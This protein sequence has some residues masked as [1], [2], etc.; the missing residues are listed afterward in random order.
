MRFFRDSWSPEPSSGLLELQEISK[1][2]RFWKRNLG[3]FE[4]EECGER[5]EELS[6][7]SSIARGE[8]RRS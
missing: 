5:N 4:I 7:E 8:R 6:D 2:L 3:G 1:V